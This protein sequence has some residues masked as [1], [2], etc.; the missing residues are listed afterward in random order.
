VLLSL[1]AAEST[2]AADLSSN[3]DSWLTAYRRVPTETP[4]LARVESIFRKLKNVAGGAALRSR[5][6]V[7]DSDNE[8]WAVALQDGNVILS[9]GAMDVVYDGRDLN[10]SDARMALIL[11]HELSHIASN[12]F[13]H[14]HVYKKF[15]AGSSALQAIQ[16]QSSQ[17]LKIRKQQELRADEEG[18]LLASLAGYD[19]RKIFSD[20]DNPE[21]FLSYWARQTNLISSDEYHAPE[22]RIAFLQNRMDRLDQSVEFFKFG[23]RLAHFGRYGDAQLMLEEFRKDYGSRQVLTNLGYTYLQLA[24]GKMPVSIAYRYWFPTMLEVESGLPAKTRTLSQS[25]PV[26]AREDLLIAV[27]YL[28]RAVN[29][30]A[31]DL[32]SKMNLVT[33]YVYLGK[34]AAARQ[35][36]DDVLQTYPD[37]A[38]FLAMKALIVLNDE[39]YPNAWNSYSRSIFDRLASYEGA[40]DNIVFNYA[41]ILDEKGKKDEAEAFWRRLAKHQNSMP[42]VYQVLVCERLKLKKSCRSEILEAGAS[43]TGWELEISPGDDIDSRKTRRILSDWNK[44]LSRRFGQVEAQIYRNQSGDA[45]L[46]VDSIVAMIVVR[47]H[48]ISFSEQLRQQHG[49]PLVETMLNGYTLWS[50]GP[51]WS[52]MLRGESVDELWMAR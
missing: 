41:K 45:L 38:Q 17:D 36:V 49:D 10:S 12:D 8:P 47:Q 31:A 6:Y 28:E 32:A 51:Q 52:A 1:G 33:A 2:I 23:V 35:L 24:R 48:G 15:L 46:A 11:G 13:W 25:L 19:T 3:V 16:G 50:Y 22:E 9:R 21:N 5:L 44:P 43:A 37:N 20:Q 42:P 30:D 18:F 26:D 27:D 40:D 14:Q 7:I 34:N 4:R 39:L 29:M